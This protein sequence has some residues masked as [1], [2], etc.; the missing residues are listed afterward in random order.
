MGASPSRRLYTASQQGDLETIRAT[1]DGGADVNARVGKRNEA[2]L[3]AAARRGHAQAVQLLL[4][5]GALDLQDSVRGGVWGGGG[6][7]EG[8]GGG[9]QGGTKRAVSR[10]ALRAL[11]RR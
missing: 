10:H 3:A 1:L 9:A 2:P 7:G 6:G 5:S 4:H 8:G 11:L